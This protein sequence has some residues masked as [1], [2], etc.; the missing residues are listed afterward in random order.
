MQSLTPTHRIE[1]IN[2]KENVWKYFRSLLA[3]RNR[4]L[5]KDD[6]R[7]AIISYPPFANAGNFVA[8]NNIEFEEKVGRVKGFLTP[9]TEIKVPISEGE[10]LIEPDKNYFERQLGLYLKDKTVNG[11]FVRVNLVSLPG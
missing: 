9:Y 8:A 6:L 11:N 2:N 5:T 10:L 7:A 3:S 4:W 1:A